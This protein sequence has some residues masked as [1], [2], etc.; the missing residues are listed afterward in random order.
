MSRFVI[1]SLDNLCFPNPN[2]V[3]HMFHVM[4][5]IISFSNRPR[6]IEDDVAPV[7]IVTGILPWFH[8][9][10]MNLLFIKA[11][12]ASCVVYLP[13]YQEEQFLHCIE[14]RACIV[15]YELSCLN[16]SFHYRNTRSTQLLLYRR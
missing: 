14:V 2:I 6:K 1:F 15:T 8:A 11:L 10:G 5:G 12:R 7:P 3:N 9:F 4:Y 16:Y 13:K